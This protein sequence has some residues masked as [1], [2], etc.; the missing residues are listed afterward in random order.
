MKTNSSGHGM[1]NDSMRTRYIILTVMA[2]ILS[3]TALQAQQEPVDTVVIA[4][5]KGSYSCE[6][7]VHH[8][9]G[10]TYSVEYD[11]TAFDCRSKIKYDY[12]LKMAAGMRGADAGRAVYSFKPRKAG[13]FEIVEVFCFRGK[14]TRRI[15]HRIVIQEL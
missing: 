8:S 1:K 2:M 7:K 6:G 5:G 15:R 9:V 3:T 13:I 4:L 12:P 10:Y 14:E 11:T